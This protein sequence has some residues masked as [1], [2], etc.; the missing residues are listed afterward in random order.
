MVQAPENKKGAFGDW[1]SACRMIAGKPGVARADGSPI[2]AKGPAL[3]VLGEM[4]TTEPEQ[5]GTSCSRQRNGGAPPGVRMRLLSLALRWPCRE[6]CRARSG[7]RRH[8]QSTESHVRGNEPPCEAAGRILLKVTNV[9]RSPIP[10]HRVD[11]YSR[12][13]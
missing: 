7:S 6:P 4:C 10:E 3:L 12:D 11:A 1:S 8:G 9:V 13:K 5:L 2:L